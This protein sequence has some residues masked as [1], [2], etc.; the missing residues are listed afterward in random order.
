MV[1]FAPVPAGRTHMCRQLTAQLSFATLGRLYSEYKVNG[2]AQEVSSVG[3][4]YQRI[5]GLQSAVRQFQIIGQHDDGYGRT[6]PL[7]LIRNH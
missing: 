3:P 4:S 6:N 1:G 5:D 2:C 7:D